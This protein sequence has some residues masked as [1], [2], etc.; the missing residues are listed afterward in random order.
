M[1]VR[2]SPKRRRKPQT[3]KA[4]ARAQTQGVFEAR[5]VLSPAH[6]SLL[7]IGVKKDLTPLT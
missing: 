3:E 5:G 2:T 6:L 7:Q 1:G 4:K